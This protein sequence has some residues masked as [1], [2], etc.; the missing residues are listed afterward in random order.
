MQMPEM[1]G[2]AATA[3][4]RRL[5]FKSL[6]IIALTAHALSEDRKR[7]LDAGCTDYL[8]KPIER[9]LLVGTVGYYINQSRAGGAGMSP[10]ASAAAAAAALAAAQP[11][12]NEADPVQASSSPPPE[13]TLSAAA[14]AAP[15]EPVLKSRYADDESML[16][17]IAQFVERLPIRVASLQEQ[18]AAGT[19]ESLRQTVHQLKGAGGGYGFPEITACAAGVERT[20]KAQ[21]AVEQI[22]TEVAA[23]TELIRRVQG[24]DRAREVKA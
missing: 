2:Y 3:E 23:L 10:E 13:G 21:A 4:L 17:P 1:D 11:A 16:E 9:E 24:Y 20:I 7:C 15:A 14:L 12:A 5:G 22:A 6:P 19:I 8:T 18:L